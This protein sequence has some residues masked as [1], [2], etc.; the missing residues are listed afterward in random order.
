M[1]LFKHSKNSEGMRV[2]VKLPAIDFTKTTQVVS[3]PLPGAFTQRFMPQA[4][5]FICK[6]AD[7]VAGDSSINVGSSSGGNQLLKE[8]N[9]EGCD[10][11]NKVLRVDVPAAAAESPMAGNDTVYAQI[12]SPDSTA[13]QGTVDLYVEGVLL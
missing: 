10:S 5:F 12:S 3:A 2:V 6:D 1:K 9:I 8:Y 7:E 13:S 11:T 4:Y